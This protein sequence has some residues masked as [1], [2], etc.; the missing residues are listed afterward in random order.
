MPLD[1]EIADPV[2]I[3]GLPATISSHIQLGIAEPVVITGLPLLVL[4][5]PAAPT[6]TPN[7]VKARVLDEDGVFIAHLPHTQGLRWLDEHNS[8]GGGS[9]DYKRYDDLETALQAEGKALWQAGN[10]ILISVGAR[11]IFRLVLDAKGGYRID[12]ITGARVDSWSGMG[13]LGVLNSGMIEPEYGWRKEATEERSFD[14][15]SNPGIG[16]WRVAS[17][18]RKPVGKPVR[19]S[20][21]WTYH[22]R[23][24][25]KGWPDRKAQWLWWKN[26]DAKGVPDEICYFASGFTITKPGRYKFWVCGDD[27]LEFQVDGEIRAT[28]GPGGWKQPTTVVLQLS[29][30]AHYVASK[31]QN[32]PATDGN[33]NRSGFLCSIARVTSDGDVIAYVRR[34]NPTHWTVRRQL[35]GPPGWFAAQILRQLVAE[36]VL[37]GC[38]GH[39]GI[40]VGFSTTQ[41]SARVAWINR[42]DLALL[43]GTLGLEYVQRMVE[44]GID[45]AMTPGLVLKAWRKRG[46]DRSKIVRLKAARRSDES[47]AQLPAI[48]NVLHGRARS[49]WV[50]RTAPSSLTAY[51]RRETV[52]TMGSSRSTTQTAAS[53]RT[54][55]DDV[56]YPPQTVE[57]KL[58]GAAG[59]QPYVD[60]DVADWVSYRAAGMTTWGRWRVM[61]IAGETNPSGLP[62]WTVQLYEDAA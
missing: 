31:V 15:G 26:P 61:S 33:S 29:A 44:T 3:S 4:E 25:P 7:G 10:Q 19:K 46:V 20:W 43:V 52:I 51:G 14:Y 36:Q 24:L 42:Q 32:S 35:S 40:F 41:D 8:P 55:I 47:A 37:R 27:T 34:T 28:V 48:R 16:G 2:E 49:G 58:S 12:E 60:F 22:R 21:R 23:H 13:A 39:G 30:G 53:L 5:P 1:L 11:D 9:V 50:E 18:W 38:A 45:V 6:T 17:E 62:D 56:A 59:P 57:V 54:M